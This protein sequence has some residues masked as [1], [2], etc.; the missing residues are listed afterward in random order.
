MEEEGKTGWVLTQTQKELFLG[1]LVILIYLL[2]RWISTKRKKK[3]QKEAEKPD[4]LTK[5]DD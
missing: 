1:L 2:Y 5:S 3:K 4:D